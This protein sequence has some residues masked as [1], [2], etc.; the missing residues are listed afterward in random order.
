MTVKGGRELLSRLGYNADKQKMMAAVLVDKRQ[1]MDGDSNSKLMLQYYK[2]RVLAVSVNVNGN[3]KIYD[4][5]DCKEKWVKYLK[6]C[7]RNDR[8]EIINHVEMP[9]IIEYD[10]GK[11]GSIDRAY[12]GLNPVDKEFYDVNKNKY[13][14]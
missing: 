13:K 2:F 3:V 12:R 1:I 4:Y 7:I 11:N 5:K 6:M 14:L 9:C 8:D 10:I